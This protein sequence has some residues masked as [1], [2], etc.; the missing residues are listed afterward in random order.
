VS[1]VPG[2]GVKVPDAPSTVPARREKSAV[3]VY[4]VAHCGQC[5]WFSPDRRQMETD[6]WGDLQSHLRNQHGGNIQE[7][8]VRR[9]VV[10]ELV[11]EDQI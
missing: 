3:Y 1:V 6:A 4:Y 5:E 8:R 11:P 10:E 9:T 7:V 2:D